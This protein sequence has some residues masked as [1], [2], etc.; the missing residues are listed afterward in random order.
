[1][2]TGIL[3]LFLCLTAPSI[4]SAQDLVSYHPE[5]A[6]GLGYYQ[7]FVSLANQGIANHLIRIEL[8][9][10]SGPLDLNWSPLSNCGTGCFEIALAGGDTF[11][12]QTSGGGNLIVGYA[13]VTASPEVRIAITNNIGL[14]GS[15]NFPLGTP[16]SGATVPAVRTSQTQTG[17]ILINP[18]SSSANFDLTANGVIVDPGGPGLA[19]DTGPG[20][21]VSPSIIYPADQTTNNGPGSCSATLNFDVTATGV[22]DPALKLR[23]LCGGSS[24]TDSEIPPP[25][26]AQLSRTGEAVSLEAIDLDAGQPSDSGPAFRFDD[27]KWVLNLSTKDLA[28]G[29]YL[30]E[31]SLPNGDSYRS[32]FSLR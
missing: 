4:V 25:L 27:D 24:L 23:L 3:Q 31:I 10:D 30:I 14:A 12:G 22:P 28:P 20:D 6:N 11:A 1:M 7:T 32:A 9:D 8:F 2:S 15:I 16:V 17:L 19:E 26:I 29:S 13:R 21:G 18:G 5:V